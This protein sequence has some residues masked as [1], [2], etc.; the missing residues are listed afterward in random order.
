MKVSDNIAKRIFNY[1]FENNCIHII[2]DN[3]KQLL[4]KGVYK[5]PDWSKN[6]YLNLTYQTSMW[7]SLAEM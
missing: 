2:H 6:S 1:G 5:L 3:D 4:Q 7:Y